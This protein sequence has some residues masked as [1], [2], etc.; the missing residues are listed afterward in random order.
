MG[1]RAALVVPMHAL[2][3]VIGVFIFHGREIREPDE[4]LL[5]AMQLIGGQIG[6]LLRRARAEDAVRESEARFRSLCELSSDV[7]WEQD[8]QFRFTAVSDS[9]GVLDQRIVGQTRWQQAVSNLTEQDWAAHRAV[10]EAHQPFRDLELCRVDPAGREAWHSVSGEPVLRRAPAPSPATAGSAATSPR[11]SSPRSASAIWRPRRADR[12]AQ[13]RRC[14]ATL[15]DVALA[16]ARAA[17]AA[18]LRGDVHRP[19]PLQDRSTTRSATTAGDELLQRGRRGACA[20]S[21]ARRATR[22]RA[23]AATSSWCCS[24]TSTTPAQAETVAQKMLDAL[25]RSRCS[26]TAHELSR[27]RAASASRSIPSDGDGRAVAAEERR[28]ARCTAP[29]SAGKNNFQFYHAGIDR[30]VAASAWRSRRS[31]RRALERDEFVLHYQPQ[32]DA[33]DRRVIGV[34]ALVRWQHPELGAG[35]AGR[36]HP[37]R[38]GDRPHRRRSA[39]WVLRSRLRA[40]AA[41]GS[42]DGLPASASR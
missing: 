32:I 35:A 24:P 9:S 30:R 26:S 34:E 3:V 12:P 2:D 14:S 36:I 25:R 10:L 16:Q 39:D 27:H 17:A 31:L 38:R 7:F 33:R 8:A 13:P 40:G 19:R 22:W 42:G 28:H 41:R 23:W 1:A 37:A 5:Q 29:R 11:A 4:R 15:L 21:A 18:P 20:H 6:Q